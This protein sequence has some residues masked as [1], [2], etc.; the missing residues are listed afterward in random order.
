MF[1]SHLKPNNL[2]RFQQLLIA[3]IRKM[4]IYSIS[5]AI[6]QL[7]FVLIVFLGI[8]FYQYQDLVACNSN[9]KLLQSYSPYSFIDYSDFLIANSSYSPPE[10][11]PGFFNFGS[12]QCPTTLS[13]PCAERFPNFQCQ[14]SCLPLSCLPHTA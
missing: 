7:L 14:V 3:Y 11:N 13:F 5:Y 2:N 1:S 12:I 6:P 10:K 4:L 9:R 8:S